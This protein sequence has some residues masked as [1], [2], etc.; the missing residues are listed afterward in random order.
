MID[1]L[2]KNPSIARLIV[3]MFE[4]R[5]D[6]NADSH[7]TSELRAQFVALLDDVSSL[8][9]DRILRTF[10]NAIAATVRTNYHK[11]GANQ[12]PLDYLSIKLLPSQIEGIPLP[13]PEFE[14]FVCSPRVE[15]THLRGG[16]VARGGLRWSDRREDFRTE[17]LGLMK[18]QMVKNSVI[19]PVGS[20]GGFVVKRPPAGGTR[21][22]LMSEV[23]HCYQTFLRGMLDITDNYIDGEIQPPLDVIRHDSDDPYLVV[24]ADKGTATFSDI[25]NGISDDYGFWLGDAFAS[26]GSVG[27]DHKGMGITAKGAWESVKRHFR[28]LN[29]DTQKETFTVVGIGDM[30]GDVFGNGM[31]LSE[32][33]QLVAAFNHLHIFLDPEPDA[34]RSF[35]ERKRLF[36]L[37]GCSWEDYDRELIS[38]GG[39][40]FSRSA[41]SIPLS[42]QVQQLIGSN[43]TAMAPNKLI[44]HL[45]KSKVDLLWNGGIGT[46]IKAST[47]SNLEAQ[48]KSNDSL[49][50]NGSDLQCKVV[51]EGGN[52]GCTQ[53]GRIEFASAGGKMYTCLLY[54]SPSPRDL[55]TSRMPSSA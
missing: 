37:P 7:D 49:R 26:G 24:A 34:A 19:V 47:E 13:C 3:E 38:A 1:C 53:L 44:H 43:E 30:A 23:V 9:E 42:P 33:I 46:Y 8:D 2:V 28:E 4:T 6:I 39:G 51:G 54:T 32:Q 15:A 20:K 18:A 10:E 41:K 35:T 48:D 12:S 45:L 36:E 55:S 25:A 31:L 17:V 40:I 22:D 16:R 21:D 14:I 52:L 5:F 29:L 27:Y 11:K 50:V